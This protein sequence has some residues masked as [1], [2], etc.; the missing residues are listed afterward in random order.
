MAKSAISRCFYTRVLYGIIVNR[1][2]NG[3]GE[4]W[5]E[6]RAKQSCKA[7]MTIAVILLI[8]LIAYIPLRVIFLYA[9][10]LENTN[11]SLK[12][13]YRGLLMLSLVNG[14]CDPLIYSIRMS[15]IRAGYQII[16]KRC[17]ISQQILQSQGRSVVTH[18][19]NTTCSTDL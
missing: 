5:N 19:E 4:F 18:F 9:I 17:L 12:Y 2:L 13:C 15:K 3:M 10:H 7:F 16:F 11:T 6:R 1:L 14:V 8:Y